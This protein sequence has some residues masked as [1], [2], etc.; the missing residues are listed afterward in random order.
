[1]IQNDGCLG[2]SVLQ[3]IIVDPET[4]GTTL[5]SRDGDGD[6]VAMSEIHVT[7]EFWRIFEDQPDVVTYRTR[8]CG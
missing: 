3:G 1:M 6:A 7:P 2:I 8:L 4:S 5:T